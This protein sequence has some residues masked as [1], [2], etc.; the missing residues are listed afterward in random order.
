MINMISA[1][2][3]RSADPHDY[4]PSIAQ[5]THVLANFGEYGKDGKPTHSHTVVIE[6]GQMLLALLLAK[7]YERLPEALEL[8][9]RLLQQAA[10]QGKREIEDGDVYRPELKDTTFTAII[11]QSIED[12]VI[13]EMARGD[14]WMRGTNGWWLKDA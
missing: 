1:R 9:L 10:E 14:K 4:S 11:P 6:A 8:S 3:L 13:A 5:A 2:G 7:G 12:A